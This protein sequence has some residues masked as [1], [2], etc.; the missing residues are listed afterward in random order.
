ME[1]FDNFAREDQ[2]RASLAIIWWYTLPGMNDYEFANK[3]I[4]M[5]IEELTER[6]RERF[7][8]AEEDPKINHEFRWFK[9]MINKGIRRYGPYANFDGLRRLVERMYTD[10]LISGK[11]KTAESLCRCIDRIVINLSFV[12][13]CEY[14]TV[15]EYRGIYDAIVRRR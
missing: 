1:K 8:E 6:I 7:E 12:G 4:N 9:R 15:V 3:L 5:P 2:E 10:K 11:S 14:D 13:R